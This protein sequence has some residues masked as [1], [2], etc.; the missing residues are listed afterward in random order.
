MG[1]LLTLF[2]G[3]LGGFIAQL[4]GRAASAGVKLAAYVT[5]GVAVV[6][7][8]LLPVASYFDSFASGYAG[9]PSGVIWFLDLLAVPQG[10]GIVG[11]AYSVRFALRRI[12]I[13]V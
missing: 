4:A 10:L 11:V 8:L 9:L 5:V 6:G 12:S 7:T 13:P 1:A 2:A 3:W